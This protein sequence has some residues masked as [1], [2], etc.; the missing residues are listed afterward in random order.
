MILE[1][2]GL[3]FIIIILFIT[4]SLVFFVYAWNRDETSHELIKTLPNSVEKLAMAMDEKLEK[5]FTKWGV[6]CAMNPWKILFLGKLKKLIN[7]N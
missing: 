6:Y 3:T 1:I 4:G 7:F 2:D 5:F